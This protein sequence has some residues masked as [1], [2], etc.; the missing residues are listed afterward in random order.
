MPAAMAKSDLAL[1][2][3]AVPVS[4]IMRVSVWLFWLAQFAAAGGATAADVAVVG[5]FPGKAVLVVDG[6][7]PRTIGIG[8]KT[9]E[10][11]RLLSIDGDFATVEIDGKRQRLGIGDQVVSQGGPAGGGAVTLTA[12]ARGHFVTG[13]IV[14][15]A[16]VRFLIDTGATM[17]SLGAT[18]AARAGVDFR[19]GEP[20]MTMTAN[21]P[22]RAYKTRISS[23]KIGEIALSDVDALVHAYDMPVALLGMSFLNRMEMR[24]DGQTMTLRRR[25]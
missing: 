14:N 13:G 22:A 21:G 7:A 10:G 6:A 25:Y 5:L 2:C 4:E 23:L 24:R 9:P 11:G 17:V 16:S 18:D 1:I 12:D 3:G 19:R 20:V 15:G 8:G